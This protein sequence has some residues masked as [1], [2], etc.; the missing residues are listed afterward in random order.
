MID[1]RDYAL[2]LIKQWEGCKLEAYPDPA[3]GGVP[4][5]IGYGATGPDIVRGTVWTQEQA[6]ADLADRTEHINAFVTQAIRVRI[7]AQQRAAMISLTYNIGTG[8]FMHSSLLTAINDADYGRACGQF[9][10]WILAHGRPMA[11]LI[12]RRAA[13]AELFAD[14]TV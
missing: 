2:P 9:G 14:G 7:T 13:E 5:T 3:S 10:V 1:W 6:D 11:G 8:S 12:R 4:W